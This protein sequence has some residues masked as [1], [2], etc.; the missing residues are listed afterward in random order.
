LLLLGDVNAQKLAAQI[1]EAMP[2][3]VGAAKFRGNFGAVYG[4]FNSYD[5]MAQHGDVESGEMKD[6]GN[7]LVSK[8]THKVGA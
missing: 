2:I 7:F 1:L 6:F 5:V 3:R 8:Q 4:T